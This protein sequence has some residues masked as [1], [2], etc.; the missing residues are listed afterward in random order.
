K[1]ATLFLAIYDRSRRTLRYANAGHL[2]ALLLRTD[3]SLRK[4]TSG[5]MVLGRFEES[6]IDEAEIEL[7][8]GDLVVA[9]SDG[10]TEPENEFGEFGEVRLIELLRENSQLPLARI[11]DE[12]R[13]AV[14]DWIGGAEQPDDLTLLLARPR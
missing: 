6:S 3:G 4:L 2:P 13:K 5:G 1:Y 11:W 12:M 9:F 7:Q 10:V 14:N 8:P